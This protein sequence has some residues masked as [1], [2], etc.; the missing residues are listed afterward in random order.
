MSAGAY[1][2]LYF[3]DSEQLLPAIDAVQAMPAVK[4]WHAVD[5]H[6]HLVLTLS[7]GSAEVKDAIAALAGMENMLFCPMDKII[8]DGFS[9]ESEPA[10]AWLTMEVDT[11]KRDAVEASLTALPATT[12]CALAFGDCG[13]V[14]AVT[15]TTFEAVDKIVEKEIRPLDGVLRVKRDWIID[16]TQI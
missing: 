4:A 1:A 7:D 15:G 8:S 5:G 14:A 6:Y 9:V 12:L 16:L 10:Y 3:Q 13:A 11:A 2:F